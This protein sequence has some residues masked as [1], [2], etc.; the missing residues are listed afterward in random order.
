MVREER[1]QKCKQV[2]VGDVR[3]KVMCVLDWVLRRLNPTERPFFEEGRDKE[4]AAVVY[5][6]QTGDFMKTMN[7][8]N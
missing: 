1:R 2:K 8:F 6:V 3:P 4:V 5:W 7:K